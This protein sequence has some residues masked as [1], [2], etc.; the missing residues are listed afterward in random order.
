MLDG[1]VACGV[2]LFLYLELY[3]QQSNIFPRNYRE[4]E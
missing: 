2:G 4:G 1:H 3:V